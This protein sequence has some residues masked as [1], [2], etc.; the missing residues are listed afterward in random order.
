MNPLLMDFLKSVLRYAL[1][2]VFAWMVERGIISPDQAETYLIAFVMFLIVTGWSLYD[3]WWKRK[4]L[5][6][7][8]AM[9]GPVSEAQ[10]ERVAQ[11]P[12]APPASLKKDETPRAMTLAG[13]P[14]K[15][16]P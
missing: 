13:T 14:A 7:A 8:Q 15:E 9:P 12:S 16:K 11:M 4:K 10:V 3:K 5:L 2:P 1:I 6:T